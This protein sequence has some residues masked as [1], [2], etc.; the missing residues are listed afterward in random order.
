[1]LAYCRE[2]GGERIACVFNLGR[3][4]VTLPLPDLAGAEPLDTGLRGE[5]DGDTVILPGHG[6]V[7]AEVS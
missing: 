2:A 4:P 1:V 3:E 6:G 5:I 7:V